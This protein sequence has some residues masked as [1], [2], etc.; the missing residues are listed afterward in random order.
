VAFL[1]RQLTP[2]QFGEEVGDEVAACNED[3]ARAV[4]V[5]SK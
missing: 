5:T 3:F 1:E 2:E 4:L